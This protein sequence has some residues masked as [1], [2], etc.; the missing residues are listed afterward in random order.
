M[1]VLLPGIRSAKALGYDRWSPPVYLALGA[2]R[3][4][5]FGPACPLDS[6]LQRALIGGVCLV[7][8]SGAPT[9]RECDVYLP[10]QPL[11]QHGH[12][13]QRALIVPVA[14]VKLTKEIVAA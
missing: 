5:G 3:T 13:L 10:R 12:A 7:E 14:E 11:A 1:G 9:A 6:R 4:T 8:T 2:Q